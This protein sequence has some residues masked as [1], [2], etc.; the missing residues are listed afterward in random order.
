[1]RET[2]DAPARRSGSAGTAGDG[3]LVAG[4]QLN[5][6]VVCSSWAERPRSSDAPA[7]FELLDVDPGADASGPPVFSEKPRAMVFALERLEMPVGRL[8]FVQPDEN[9]ATLRQ[10]AEIDLAVVI[11]VGGDD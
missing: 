2:A 4:R 3:G 6:Y 5:S 9:A 7:A 1:M 10:R 8:A 11:D